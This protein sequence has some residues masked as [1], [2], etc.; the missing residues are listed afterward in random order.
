[1]RKLSRK[2]SGMFVKARD[3]A[4][5][6]LEESKEEPFDLAGEVNDDVGSL[7]ELPDP[8]DKVAYDKFCE[9]VMARECIAVLSR[10]QELIRA[11]QF[12]RARAEHPL[13]TEEV[14]RRHRVVVTMMRKFNRRWGL[15]ISG[16]DTLIRGS[17]TT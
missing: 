6:E 4:E 5:D 17:E 14:R 10:Q 15:T 8:S 12:L 2:L 11:E 3:G 1:M 9:L 7:P 13:A 16:I